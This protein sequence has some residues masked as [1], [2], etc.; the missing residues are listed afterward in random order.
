MKLVKYNQI[1]LPHVKVYITDVALNNRVK[2]T[3]IDRT[4]SVLKSFHGGKIW[5]STTT[6]Q[7]CTL[8][9]HLV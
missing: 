4:D 8:T 1:I 2:L 7:Q 9:V 5:L 3:Q 6:C